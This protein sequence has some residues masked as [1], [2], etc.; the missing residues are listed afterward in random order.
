MHKSWF[1]SLLLMLMMTT[2]L[3]G[4]SRESV[5]K[6]IQETSKWTPAGEPAKYDEKN[7]EALAGK[8]SST[9]AHYGLRGAT[10]Q[11]WSGPEGTVRLS[12]YEMS[13]AGAAYG[14]FTLDRN[15]DVQGFATIPIGSEG[16]RVGERAEFRQ[17]K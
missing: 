6:V 11:S 10:R 16:F 13:D 14:L 5:F 17:S 15:I 9:I 3:I 4:Q 8:R 1:S 12:L 2:A 7:L